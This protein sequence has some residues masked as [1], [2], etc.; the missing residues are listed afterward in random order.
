MPESYGLNKFP[1]IVCN[2]VSISYL[3]SIQNTPIRTI[4]Y[5]ALAFLCILLLVIWLTP[6]AFTACSPGSY[7][8]LIAYGFTTSGG[9]V[10]FFILLLLTGFFYTLSEKIFRQKVIIFFKSVI[11]LILVFGALAW[12][13]EHYTKPILKLQRPSHVYMLKQTHIADKIDTLYTLGKK[14]RGEFFAALVKDHIDAFKDIDARV[15]QHWI[16][17]AGFSFPSGHTFNAFLFA[18]VI[19]Y[20]IYFNRSRPKL[21]KLFFLPFAWAAGVGISR[22]A[23]GAHTA[24]DVSAGATLGILIGLLFLY[25]DFTRHWLTRK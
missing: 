9:A 15:Q 21:R 1:F 25:I 10:G 17:E 19:A 18:M 20:A 23:M 14:E 2:S 13:N 4:V 22:V 7:W 6:I 3:G 5:T 11:S 8:C 12:V 24:L 16:D